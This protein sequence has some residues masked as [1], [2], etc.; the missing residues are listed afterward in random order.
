MAITVQ[1][2]GTQLA[3]IGTEHILFNNYATSGSYRFDVDLGNMAG[4]DTVE[5]RLYTKVLSTGTEHLHSYATFTGAVAADNPIIQESLVLSSD[6]GCKCTL[7]QTAGTGRNFDWK[8]VT[9]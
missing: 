4:G 2:S 6:L 5:L 1:A 3:V 8:T 7:K 9:L